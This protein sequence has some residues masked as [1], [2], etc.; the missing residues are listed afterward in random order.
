MPVILRLLKE[1]VPAL[2]VAELFSMLSV[3]LSAS[4]VVCVKSRS[5][6]PCAS[7]AF[8]SGCVP[9]AKPL[10]ASAGWWLKTHWLATTSALK[11]ELEMAVR[12]PSLPLVWSS[13]ERVNIPPS[14]AAS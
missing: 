1:A 4:V 5:V 3:V 9:T 13:K 11:D 6:V 12:S 8:S 14:V 10:R 2:A 7:R